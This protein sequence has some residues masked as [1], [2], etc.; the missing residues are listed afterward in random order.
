MKEKKISPNWYIAAT[1]W[2]TSGFVI[3][4]LIVFV[5]GIPLSLLI[6]DQ[7]PVVYVILI[8]AIQ[9][10]S[11]WLGIMYSSK[12][13]ARTYIVSNKEKVASL[14]TIYLVVI[15]L[16]FRSSDYIRNPGMDFAR[17]TDWVMFAI[18][19]ILFYI[20]SKKYIKNTAEVPVAAPQAPTI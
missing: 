2:L 14:A 12:Y 9:I 20:L 19:A 10:L 6:G 4:L 13:V 5:V 11:V 16:L 15:G 17:T 18:M 3:P 7:S 1:H 8:A